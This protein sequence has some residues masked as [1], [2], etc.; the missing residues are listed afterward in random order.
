[1]SLIYQHDSG[2]SY[3]LQAIILSNDYFVSN[4]YATW[5]DTFQIIIKIIK[6]PGRD[7]VNFQ[8]VSTPVH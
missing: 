6:M 7:S 5:I 1:M 2:Y 3:S 4:A 8:N